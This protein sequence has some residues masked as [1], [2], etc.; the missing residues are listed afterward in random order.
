MTVAVIRSAIRG[1]I[2]LSIVRIS[3]GKSAYGNDRDSSR[4]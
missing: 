2:E 1:V 4:F 3:P